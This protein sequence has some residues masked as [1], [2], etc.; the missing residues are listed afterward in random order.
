MKPNKQENNLGL[1]Q[2]QVG[3]GLPH[4]SPQAC[5]APSPPVGCVIPL[6]LYLS[7]WI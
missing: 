1:P 5:I 2:S 6:S 3:T 7:S 4:P